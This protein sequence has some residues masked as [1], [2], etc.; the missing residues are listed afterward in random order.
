[1]YL[2]KIICYISILVWL[3]PPFRQYKGGY[4]LYFLIM[5]YSDPLT[6]TLG[7]IFK[8]NANYTHL[9]IAFLLTISI[10]F[11][12]KNLNYKW[13]IALFLF[14]IFSI[15]KGDKE[16][17][18]LSIIIFHFI[19]FTQILIPSI[20]EFYIKQRINLYLTILSV[21]E[22]TTIFK[23]TA[24]TYNYNSGVYFFYLSVAFE[25]LI[26]LFFIF[27]NLNNSPILKLPFRLSEEH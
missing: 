14:L 23:Y 10:L 24:F 25:L 16:I 7:W 21:Y 3:L 26:G 5:G 1:M 17:R 19:I 22:L 11:Y 15:V 20:K 12:N 27:I 6:L 8:I 4:F 2:V 9:V 18:Y 13:I